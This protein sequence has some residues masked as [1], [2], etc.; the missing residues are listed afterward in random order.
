MPSSS[1]RVSAFR[2]R[3]PLTAGLA[4]AATALAATALA[5]PAHAA[6]AP[7]YK[8]VLSPIANSDYTG[9]NA[10]GDIVGVAPQNGDVQPALFRAGSTSPTFLGPLATQTNT[11]FLNDS[12]INNADQVVGQDTLT[13]SAL[14]WPN[15]ATPTDLSKVSG[16]AGVFRDTDAIAINN[17]G[18]VVGHGILG[19]KGS[20]APFAITNNVAS[21]LPQLPN[22][23]D[24]DP[25][26]VND[27]G[28]I[29]GVADTATQNGQAVEW[30]NGSIKVLPSLAS[31]D[32]SRALAI[33]ASG[34]VV[35]NAV[36]NTDFN[37]R[38]VLWAN[39]TATALNFGNGDSSANAINSGGVIVG[40]GPAGVGQGV[41]TNAFIYKN[42][43][44][45]NL[46]TLI[47]ANS[48]VVLTV[49]TGINDKGDIVGTAD[50]ING[51][52][53]GFEL[54]PVS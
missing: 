51:Q 45:T 6:T 40:D 49:A 10:T 54:I 13:G 23:V 2:A 20:D 53:F 28:V 36:L 11:L 43:T 19:N 39:G 9:I 37:Q 35:G 18:E 27:S 29:V 4:V 38:A 32:G 15:S 46:N 3:K 44:A 33:N 24:G 26:A 21:K 1:R 30:S 7:Q 12:G 8:L 47:P 31:T 34:A 22:G 48:G 25:L 42:G 41:D 52:E 16:L 17:N 50:Q 14:L 5:G